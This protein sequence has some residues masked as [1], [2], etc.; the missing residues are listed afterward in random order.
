MYT[1]PLHKR[2]DSTREYASRQPYYNVLS[3]VDINLACSDDGRAIRDGIMADFDEL[4][5]RLTGQNPTVREMQLHLNNM[6]SENQ[7]IKSLVR[8]LYCDMRTNSDV[9]SVLRPLVEHLERAEGD[10]NDSVTFFAIW[11]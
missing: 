7:K 8:K 2:N 3:F 10:G 5:H 9:S 6:A 4:Y 11:R 1:F